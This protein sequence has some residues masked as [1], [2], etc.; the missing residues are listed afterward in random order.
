MDPSSGPPARPGPVFRHASRTT[1]TRGARVRGVP[2]QTPDIAVRE[3]FW[4]TEVAPADTERRPIRV[5]SPETG[6]WVSMHVQLFEFELPQRPWWI[7]S[8]VP[9]G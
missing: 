6:E 5:R 2:W 8:L 3:R 7:Y 4:S 9:V 1:A